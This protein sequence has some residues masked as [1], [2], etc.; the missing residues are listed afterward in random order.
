ML[1]QKE[2]PGRS[3]TGD[4]AVNVTVAP[5]LLSAGVQGINVPEAEQNT[6]WL[7]V[8]QVGANSKLV[9]CTPLTSPMN[10]IVKSSTGMLAFH[11]SKPR[12]MPGEPQLNVES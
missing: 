4:G 1:M 12:P 2:S 7:P 8:P 3:M 9:I 10:V 6:V 5:P 11:V